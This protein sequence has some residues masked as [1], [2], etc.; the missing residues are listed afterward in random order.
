M[1]R[2]VQIKMSIQGDELFKLRGWAGWRGG[3]CVMSLSR[4]HQ[5]GI[6]SAAQ[7]GPGPGRGNIHNTIKLLQ[8]ETKV[9]EDFTITAKA[10]TTAF[11]QLKLP[12]SAFTFRTLTIKTLCL[13]GVDPMV[14]R[15]EIGTPVPFDLN[16][17]IVS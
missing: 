6:S 7:R 3:S 14:S 10:P 11:I 1:A 5:R 4:L 17:L 12:T 15:Y 8:L 2:N 16:V 13:T 9:R